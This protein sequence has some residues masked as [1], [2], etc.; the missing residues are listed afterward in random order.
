MYD[1]FRGG[2]KFGWGNLPQP[3]EQGG[4][5]GGSGT[6]KR[7]ANKYMYRGRERNFLRNE[8]LVL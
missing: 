7:R 4:R 1:F 8:I 5:S 2:G 3:T 6:G